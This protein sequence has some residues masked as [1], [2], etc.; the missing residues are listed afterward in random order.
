MKNLFDFATKELSQDAFLRWA[1][2]HCND[3]DLSE[4]S[5]E[6]ISFLTNGG[7]LLKKD[8]VSRVI[9]R[10]QVGK[11]DIVVQINTVGGK[12][13]LIAIEDKTSSK[14]HYQL[15]RYNEVIAEK[16]PFVDRV[17]RCYY[18]TEE[19]SPSERDRVIHSGWDI[20]EYDDIVGF[21]KKYLHSENLI[22][23]Q[24]AQSLVSRQIIKA[25]LEE[26]LREYQASHSDT[27]SSMKFG[28]K[29][30]YIFLNRYKSDLMTDTKWEKNR[31]WVAVYLRSYQ[32]LLWV[33]CGFKDG[34]KCI[35]TPGTFVESNWWKDKYATLEDDIGS[36][37]DISTE[38]GRESI[39]SGLTRSIESI[40]N[41]S[42]IA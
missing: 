30:C 1:L 29:Y 40:A 18:K 2:C 19:A 8:D 34:R 24:Y 37:S 23:R 13:Y 33:Y 31:M 36:V 6:F 12:R 41:S 9:V 3:D 28:S 5:C 25:K 17:Y 26:L 35:S 4:F 7:L 22:I 21:W 32:G 42:V 10:P 20:L 14:E 38:N 16:Y 39:L 15:I 27:V 11:L